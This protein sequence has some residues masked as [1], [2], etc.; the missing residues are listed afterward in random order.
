MYAKGEA[1]KMFDINNVRTEGDISM[2]SERRD[3]K[4]TAKGLT[5]HIEKYQAARK[6]KCNQGANM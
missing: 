1:H 4:F 5:Y 2:P 3:I 6:S